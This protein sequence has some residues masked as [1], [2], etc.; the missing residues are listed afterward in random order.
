MWGDF[1]WLAGDGKSWGLALSIRTEEWGLS[2]QELEAT[3]S[4]LFSAR[5]GAYSGQGAGGQYIT[6]VPKLNLV[7]AH[8]LNT[9]TSKAVV[10]RD[11]FDLVDLI[12]RARL[13]KSR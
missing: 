12:V 13:A 7:V 1:S 9:A 2:P 5:S 6:V 10:S 11:Y 8:K 4:D 3:V